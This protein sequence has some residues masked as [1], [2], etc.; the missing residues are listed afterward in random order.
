LCSRTRWRARHNTIACRRSFDDNLQRARE[1]ALTRL[2]D[3][4]KTIH[5]IAA[6]SGHQTLKEIERYT[7]AADQ[8]RLAR[9]ALLGEQIRTDSVEPERVR[10]SKPLKALVKKPRCKHSQGLTL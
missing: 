4:G 10:V 9:E 3:A 2:A 5:Q 1:A 7:K 6:V 8:R